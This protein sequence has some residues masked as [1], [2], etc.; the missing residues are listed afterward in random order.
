[1]P[2]LRAGRQA[3]PPSGQTL[4]QQGPDFSHELS[5]TK[6]RP[7]A[8]STPFSIGG[9]EEH[10]LSSVFPAWG[11]ECLLLHACQAHFTLVP[12][13]SKTQSPDVFETREIV[14]GDIYYP[15]FHLPLIV[16]NNYRTTD[17]NVP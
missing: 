5:E 3:W 14:T 17:F 9:E 10:S 11:S 8:F 1:M 13:C 15:I 16:R 12:S 2:C 7:G 4:A 6:N